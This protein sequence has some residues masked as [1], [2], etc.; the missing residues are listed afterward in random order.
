MQTQRLHA[1]QGLVASST[2]GDIIRS[3]APQSRASTSS[4]G[5]TAPC[6]WAMPTGSKPTK[7]NSPEGATEPNYQTARLPN[8]SSSRQVK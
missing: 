6:R 4:E 8:S 1:A 7:N 3:M 5:A 2:T